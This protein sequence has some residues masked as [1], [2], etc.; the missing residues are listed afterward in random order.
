MGIFNLKHNQVMGVEVDK[1]HKVVKVH[2]AGK[3]EPT[4]WDVA[5]KVESANDLG[6]LN[7]KYDRFNSTL[8]FEPTIHKADVHG[9]KKRPFKLW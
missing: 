9:K 1:H 8:E 5:D 2:V 7:V 3:N 6:L 4:L